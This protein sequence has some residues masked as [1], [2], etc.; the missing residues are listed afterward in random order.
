MSS[1]VVNQRQNVR[2]YH[3][4]LFSGLN[5]R[6]P[7]PPPNCFYPLMIQIASNNWLVCD[8]LS[9]AD[10][11]PNYSLVTNSDGEQLYKCNCGRSYRHLSTLG[12]HL[13]FECGKRP[14]FVCPHCPYSAKQKGNLKRHVLGM[15]SQFILAPPS[16]I[17]LDQV[18]PM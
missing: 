7:L 17:H 14:Q 13:K 8:V 9:V 2:V 6:F 3:M 12:N 16:S 18:A 4:G 11:A 15:H 1:H 10:N 5:L